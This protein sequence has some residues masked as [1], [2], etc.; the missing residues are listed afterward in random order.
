MGFIAKSPKKTNM[1]CLIP[2]VKRV[3]DVFT[4]LHFRHFESRSDRRFFGVCWS[5]SLFASIAL[6]KEQPEEQP[7]KPQHRATATSTEPCIGPCWHHAPHLP[8]GF[9]VPLL[10]GRFPVPQLRPDSACMCL[11]FQN[12][13]WSAGGA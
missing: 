2:L 4:T 6:S 3:L 11:C 13:P 1:L 7:C 5:S 9:L 12:H 8:S 10:G